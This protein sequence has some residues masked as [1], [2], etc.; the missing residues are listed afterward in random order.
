MN[1]N[2]YIPIIISGFLVIVLIFGYLILYCI[3][4]RKSSQK[5]EKNQVSMKKSKCSQFLSYHILY[6]FFTSDKYLMRSERI[7]AYICILNS[8][9]VIEGGLVVSSTFNDTNE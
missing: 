4:N 1:P 6:G 7:I 3:E 5:I 8:G 9:L 2:I